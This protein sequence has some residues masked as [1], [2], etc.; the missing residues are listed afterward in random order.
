[1]PA[2]SVRGD[3]DAGLAASAHRFTGEFEFGGQEHFYLETNAALAL[4]DEAGQIFVQSSTQH[5][6]ETQEIVAHVL[7]LTQPRGDGAMPAHRRWIRRQGDAA[8]RL[9]RG[10]RARARPSPVDRCCCGSTAPRTS[11]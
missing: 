11:R 2:R 3:A 1:M 6:S 7:G 8:A 5:P 9:R 10:R 4:V